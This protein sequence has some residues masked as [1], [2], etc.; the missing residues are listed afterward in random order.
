MSFH[1]FFPDED[2]FLELET[3]LGRL[4]A[5]EIVANEHFPWLPK[6]ESSMGIIPSAFVLKK[7]IPNRYKYFALWSRMAAPAAQLVLSLT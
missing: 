1:N 7:L 5:P 6:Q 2:W 4:L 3:D